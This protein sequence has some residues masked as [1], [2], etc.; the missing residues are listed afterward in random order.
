M[1]LCASS[2]QAAFLFL[3]LLPR[4]QMCSEM[5]VHLLQ[6]CFPQCWGGAEILPCLLCIPGCWVL[7][8]QVRGSSL[9]SL[10]QETQGWFFLHSFPTWEVTEV[11]RGDAAVSERSLEHRKEETM[12]VNRRDPPWWNVGAENSSSGAPGTSCCPWERGRNNQLFLPW[13]CIF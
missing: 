11:P 8:L 3:L 5:L 12:G 9:P 10:Q 2:L 7:P 13:V 6:E 1:P 4:D